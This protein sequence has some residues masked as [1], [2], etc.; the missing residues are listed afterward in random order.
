MMS[1]WVVM[2]TYTPETLSS[3]RTVS[4]PSRSGRWRGGRRRRGRRRRGWRLAAAHAAPVGREPEALPAGRPGGDAQ[5]VAARD[6]RRSGR[7]LRGSG[8]GHA[9]GG[10]GGSAAHARARW[11]DR[12]GEGGREAGGGGETAGVEPVG[13]RAG[14]GALPQVFPQ[15]PHA[16]PR[17]RCARRRTGRRRRA[18]HQKAGHGAGVGHCRNAV[19][20]R[21]MFSPGG[22]FRGRCVEHPRSHSYDCAVS[23]IRL[24]D[25]L[26]RVASL[27]PRPGPGHHQEGVR[28]LGQGPPGAA[29]QVRRALPGPPAGGRGHPRRAE[30]GRGLHRHRPAPRHHRGH[31]RHR[32][33]ATELFGP[34][35][36]QLVDGVTKLSKFSASRHALP[37]GEAGGELPEDDHRDGAGHPRHPGEAGG[38]HAQHADAG[39]HVARRSSR[40]SPRRRWTSTRRWPT[41]WASAGSRPSWRTCRFRYL[42][43]QELRRARPSKLGKRKKEREKYIEDVVAAHRARSSRSASSRATSAAASSTSTASTRRCR[44]RASSSSRCH[45][46]IA[47]R[48]AHARPCPP[49]TRRWGWCTSCGSRCR[50]A[51]RTSSRSPSRTCTSRCT[52]R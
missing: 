6:R 24:N 13:F 1:S 21:S 5:D 30:A 29:S 31:P 50:G 18:D 37:G 47:F 49:A 20:A 7:A 28:L 41:A 11:G 27:P 22:Q 12:G 8:P 32:R 46:I 34:E 2:A 4:W 45:D 39:A 40:A 10:R 15:V 3:S 38:P 17:P 43:P 48:H 51:S 42:K 36:A 33:G 26:Q 44:R 52:P 23:M 14:A 19:S 16:A 25:I 9:A 35:V